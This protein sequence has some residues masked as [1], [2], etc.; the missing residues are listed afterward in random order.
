M[1]KVK[2]LGQTVR[3][4]RP[5]LYEQ[6]PPTHPDILPLAVVLLSLNLTNSTRPIIFGWKIEQ[7][8]F[9]TLC[10]EILKTCG[11]RKTLNK[12]LLNFEFRSCPFWVRQFL[13]IRAF[14]GYG[15]L[16]KSIR[17]SASTGQTGCDTVARPETPFQPNPAQKVQ[18][19]SFEL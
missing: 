10:S 6:I 4:W 14:R 16:G 8:L 11:L 5:T 9:R 1:L 2:D 12:M 7:E 13:G 18:P 15:D 3:D 17:L 19:N